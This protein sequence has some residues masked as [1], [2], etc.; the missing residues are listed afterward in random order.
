MGGFGI[1]EQA[2]G[3]RLVALRCNEQRFKKNSQV[4]FLPLQGTVNAAFA[5]EL[6]L[7]AILKFAKNFSDDQLKKIGH[8]LLK[9]FQKIPDEIQNTITPSIDAEKLGIISN[10]FDNWRYLFEDIENKM[11]NESVTVYNLM[12]LLYKSTRSYKK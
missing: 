1:L 2:D 7:K 9:L 6:Y 8:N 11:H 3:F 10:T 12:D 4:E 5:S